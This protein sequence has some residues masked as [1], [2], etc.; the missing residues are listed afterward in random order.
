MKN[1]FV[2]GNPIDHSLSPR[3]HNFWIKKNNINAVYKKKKLSDEDLE[4]LILKIKQKEIDGI[5]VTVPFKKKVISY[6][7]NLTDEA[8]LT[9]SVNTIFLDNDKIT[10]H[11]TDIYG[12]ISAF[13]SVKYDI[14]GKK[15]LILGAG[16][17]VSSIIFALK[18]LK[19]KKIIISN[20]T[21]NKADSLKNLFKDLTVINWGDI[22]EFDLVVN[23]T[24]IGLKNEEELNLDFLKNQ[25]D[26]FFYDVIYN[27]KETNFLK[28]AKKRGNMTEN[29]KKMFIYQAAASFKIWHG[30][31][32]AIDDE[33]S[34]LLDQ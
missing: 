10:G 4:N 14:S 15:I 12:F 5:N 22:S 19:A 25:K 27:L 16:G 1:Y 34:E 24:S 26:K 8:K 31:E 7:E 18:K 29:G 9:E 32:P 28:S 13:K 30:I 20:R 3:L 6:L 21:R 23:A 2:I 33:I 17:V 11:N